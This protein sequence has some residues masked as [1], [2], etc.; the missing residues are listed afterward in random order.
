MCTGF[1]A[2]A[3]E[4]TKND[5]PFSILFQPFTCHFSAISEKENHRDRPWASGQSRPVALRCRR[6]WYALRPAGE[7][8]KSSQVFPGIFVVSFRWTDLYCKRFGIF[9]SSE[10]ILKWFTWFGGDSA[11]DS[12]KHILWDERRAF[13]MQSILGW[14]AAKSWNR[15]VIALAKIIY[16]YTVYYT[17]IFQISD[18]YAKNWYKVRVVQEY[19][20]RHGRCWPRTSTS[21]TTR[22]HGGWQK[23]MGAVKWERC[24]VFFDA[25][26]TLVG[27]TL[28]L[29]MDSN[30]FRF[31]QFS[32]FFKNM[33]VA[34]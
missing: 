21:P 34:I 9:G 8:L 27:D 12:K 5:S 1:T 11:L 4:T 23:I 17:Y 13:D 15:L 25:L 20:R 16:I 14:I 29:A 28:L 10:L 3:E 30:D 6:R 7:G 31:H 18:N 33:F 32:S 2:L 24:W 26:L 22:S 19:H